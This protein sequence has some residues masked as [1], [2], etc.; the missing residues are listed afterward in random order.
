MSNILPTGMSIRN[1]PLLPVPAAGFLATLN[2]H[3]RIKELREGQLQYI[4][5]FLCPNMAEKPQALT[6]GVFIN[7]RNVHQDTVMGSRS[8]AAAPLKNL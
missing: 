4:E 8:S 2:T 5:F 7:R 3:E 1:P 6:R